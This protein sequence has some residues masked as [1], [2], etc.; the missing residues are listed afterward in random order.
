MSF[1]SDLLFRCNEEELKRIKAFDM[2]NL[3]RKVMHA[4][5]EQVNTNTLNE[6][7]L[8]EQFGLSKS[9]YDKV[10]SVL[11]NACVTGLTNGTMKAGLSFFLE[12]ELLT[13]YVHQLKLYERRLKQYPDKVLERE[14]YWQAFQD[15]RRFPVSEYDE[16]KVKNYADK[17]L[18]VANKPSEEDKAEVWLMYEF[19]R[20]FVNAARGNNVKFEPAFLKTM[21][22]W[23]DKVLDRPWY[24]AHFHYYLTWASFYD[25]FTSDIIG[26][27]GSLQGALDAFEKAKG[28]IPE[29][30]KVYAIT[31]L[32]K[33]YCL[34]SRYEESLEVYRE[35]FKNYGTQL[36]R[37]YYHPLMYSI[38]AIINR[39]Y[40]EAELMMDKELKQLIDKGPDSTISFDILRTY[41]ILNIYRGDYKKAAK[42]LQRGLTYSRIEISRLGDILQ[43]LVHNVFFIITGDLETAKSSLSRNYKFLKSKPGDKLS[44]EYGKY[45]DMLKV[46]IAHKKGKKLP[47]DFDVQMDYFQKGIMKLYGGLLLLAMEK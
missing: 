24:K 20:V 28:A 10:N 9:H 43:R 31:K 12:K 38:I 47:G 39:Q 6:P 17:Y 22:E 2:Q 4:L 13:L 15:F 45:F 42:Y 3:H 11:F 44:E 29:N 16:R 25:F 7:S 33:A 18:K 41:A 37:N 8:Q 35:A 27:V 14:L 5:I 1:L 26:L 40:N 19:S 46:I 34:D 30:Y 32:A 23:E 36:V 21:K